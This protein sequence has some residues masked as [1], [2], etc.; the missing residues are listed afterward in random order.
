[1]HRLE[2]AILLS[3]PEFEVKSH[4]TFIYD[5]ADSNT[6]TLTGKDTFHCMGGLL[7]NTPGGEGPPVKI[8]ERSVK[9]P[10]AKDLGS[11]GKVSIKPYKKPTI[12]GL[13]L[14]QI[15]SLH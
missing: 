1:M 12:R 8:L 15:Q 2:A 11:F 13:K 9:I 5:N 14:V 3:K 7:V 10:S 4:P 6:N